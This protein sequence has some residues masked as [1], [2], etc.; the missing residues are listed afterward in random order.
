M[1][2]GK[3]QKAVLGIRLISGLLGG[4]VVLWSMSYSTSVTGSF[5]RGTSSAIDS[6]YSKYIRSVTL[7]GDSD[8]RM[9][10][11]AFREIKRR[12]RERQ[13]QRQQP[14]SSKIEKDPSRWTEEER[15]GMRHEFRVHNRNSVYSLLLPEP[16]A[17]DPEKPWYDTNLQWGYDF[18][19]VHE[20]F[21]KRS[22]QGL[23]EYHDMV[24]M[25]IEDEEEAVA[26]RKSQE[27]LERAW[28][29]NNNNA[30][31]RTAQPVRL[32]GEH[33]I[34]H[35]FQNARDIANFRTPHVLI[36]HLNENWGTLSTEVENRTAM[37]GDILGGVLNRDRGCDPMEVKELYLDSPNTLAVFTTQH[38]SIFDHPKVHSIP[39]GYANSVDGGER[40]LRTL[41]EQRSKTTLLPGVNDDP[42]S[43]LLMMNASPTE[44]RKPQIDAV[45]RNFAREGVSL[46]NTYDT[47][48]DY[49]AGVKRYMAEMSRSKFIFCPSGLGW[50][51]YRIWEAIA[52][53]TIPIIE[54]HRYRYQRLAF[55]PGSGRRDVILRG[56]AKGEVEQP[57]STEHAEKLRK[58]NATVVV[59]D[60]YDGWRK[61]LEDLPV[62][63]IDG[64]ES[65]DPEPGENFLT[66]A[67][68]ER[69]YDAMAARME[70]FRYEKLTSLYWI[71]MIE[72]HLLLGDP[73][74]A[75]SGE[76]DAPIRFED[77]DERRTWEAAIDGLSSTYNDHGYFSEPWLPPGYV[78]GSD[79]KKDGKH[80]DGE[81]RNEN[82]D[83]D[84][85]ESPYLFGVRQPDVLAWVLLIQLKI[86]GLFMV[87]KGWELLTTTTLEVPPTAK[88]R[89]MKSG[90][91][92][93]GSENDYDDGPS[94]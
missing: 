80:H 23:Y 9:Y 46:Y 72:S 5:G 59:D 56:M 10:P 48:G 35:A 82:R 51:S 21:R 47:R 36:A 6:Y 40:L 65:E 93:A 50:D 26:Y 37:W 74:A 57:L 64:F 55:P 11:R 49:V 22:D 79:A 73:V 76:V 15:S 89:R 58:F 77:P 29:N 92:G 70:S 63:W 86:L 94:V 67:F 91:G 85:R 60:Y 7:Q 12:E 66:P 41:A 18:G 61:S 20:H 54:R 25:T 24:G 8:L 19:F 28:G 38:Q 88:R 53:G 44:T 27:V 39:I 68:L 83:D 78:G 43:K 33:D 31:G 45:I 81:H 34:C 13:R 71:R 17:T 87:V 42:R 32:I 69:E 90:G 2:K 52:M 84:V 30:P 16:N 62:I 1:A 14:P 75:V 4:V 3:K